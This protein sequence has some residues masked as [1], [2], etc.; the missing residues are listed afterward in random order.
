MN[1][2]IASWQKW[3]HKYSW[4]VFG[5]GRWAVLEWCGAVVVHL[6]PDRAQAEAHL[7]YS[8]RHGCGGCCRGDHEIVDTEAS[9]ASLYGFFEYNRFVALRANMT[10]INPQKSAGKRRRAR[11]QSTRRQSAARRLDSMREPVQG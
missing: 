4:H 8:A 6:Y 10:S 2:N 5:E 1:G 3:F 11:N 9:E 7:A